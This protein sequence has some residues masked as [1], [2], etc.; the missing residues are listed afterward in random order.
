MGSI[1]VQ[2][3]SD[4][5]LRRYALLLRHGNDPYP[6]LAQLL[7]GVAAGNDDAQ[8]SV[9]GDGSMLI[10]YGSLSPASVLRVSFS[11]VLRYEPEDA[12]RLFA[13]KIVVV[14]AT[15]TGGVDYGPTPLDPLSPRAFAQIYTVNTLL[16]G[17]QL[18]EVPSAFPYLLALLIVG[19]LTTQIPA[20]HP[21]QLMGMAAALVGVLLSGTL[22]LLF[23]GGV[24]LPPVFPVL[25]T[26]IAASGYGLEQWWAANAHLKE[27]NEELSETLANLKQTRS[28]KERMEAELNIARDIQFSMLPQQFPPFPER[29]EFS[30]HATLVPA[31][32]VGGDF[33]DFFLLDPGHLYVCV[34]D[35]S[36]KGVPAALFM[37]VSKAILK[38]HAGRE[39][40]PA[41]ILT[42]ANAELAQDND[43]ALF[44]TVWLGILDVA[45]GE[46]I[47]ANAGHNP[48]MCGRATGVSYGWPHVTDRLSE[49]SRRSSTGKVRSI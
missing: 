18:R 36:D 17:R 28:V 24:V 14:G 38:S 45:T 33:Y 27:R 46:L 43:L 49:R 47:F 44:V 12:R 2:E 48:P 34:A 13:D 6:S 42:R 4:G 31:R 39:P 23:A 22:V 37:A 16:T 3:D 11:D 10:N 32:A 8:V 40:S 1:A 26:G 35:V 5:S 9:R 15:Y 30:L 20:R 19:L 7:A 41:A 29:T 25:A 21:L